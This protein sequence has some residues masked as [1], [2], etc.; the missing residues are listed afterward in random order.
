MVARDIKGQERT[1]NFLLQALKNGCLA[2][3]LLFIGPS[4]VGKSL[5]AKFLAKCVNCLDNNDGACGRC[6]SCLKI[7]NMNHLDVYWFEK[8]KDGIVKV[9]G[10]EINLPSESEEEKKSKAI[11]IKHVRFL[12]ERTQVRPYEG[13]K[14][15]FI[16]SE[17]QNL[18]PEASNA[19][20]KT[21]EEPPADSLLILTTAH[22]DQLF[23]TILSRC[24][25]FFFPVL[26]PEALKEILI[27]DYKIEERIAHFLAYFSE[28]R[29]G[30]SIQFSQTDILKRKNFFLDNFLR[31]FSSHDYFDNNFFEN[32]EGLNEGLEI[33]LNW[34][35]DILLLKIGWEVRQLVNSDRGRELQLLKDKYSF[36][37]LQEIL[38]DIILTLKLLQQNIN[39][40]ISF[41]ALRAKLCQNWYG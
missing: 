27:K 38:S 9:N 20:L 19:L 12:E 18:T 39:A 23:P 4:G 2:S 32:K 36:S 34:F 30:K 3:S 26:N 22:A 40:K 31:A 6:S 28:G 11:K 7:E 14:K 16:I 15:V 5:M 41:F 33:L 8:D 35:R 21:L 1:Q 37:D 24:Q 13:K 10:Q 29:I 17:A 25:K